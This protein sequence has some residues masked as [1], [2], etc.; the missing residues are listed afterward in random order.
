MR[1]FSEIEKHNRFEQQRSSDCP[2]NDCPSFGPHR[3]SNSCQRARSPQQER[4]HWHAPL[5]S[6]E[7]RQHLHSTAATDATLLVLLCCGPEFDLGVFFLLD[8]RSSF[9]VN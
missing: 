5:H 8:A 4:R 2:H 1:C 3:F 6:L 9:F 7:D